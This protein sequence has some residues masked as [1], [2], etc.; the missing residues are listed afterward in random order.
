MLGVLSAGGRILVI[1]IIFAFTS[2][3][4]FLREGWGEARAVQDPDGFVIPPMP[5]RPPPR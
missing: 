2:C 5:T 3:M 1:L 4:F